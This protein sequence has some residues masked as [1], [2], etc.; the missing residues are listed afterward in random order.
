MS[1]QNALLLILPFVTPLVGSSVAA[2]LAQSR[3]PAWA[4]DTVA[5]SLLLLF[6]GGDMYANAQFSGGWVMIVADSIQTVT[7]LASGWLVK[8]APWLAWLH[9]LQVNVFDLVP[10]FEEALHLEASTQ[11]VTTRAVPPL[12]PMP[13]VL[14]PGSSPVPPRA[15]AGEQEPSSK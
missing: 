3:W 5:W 12:V 13:I 15:S 10:L 11:T 8:L 1:L 4:N 14:P 7:F 9:F 6:A 2:I